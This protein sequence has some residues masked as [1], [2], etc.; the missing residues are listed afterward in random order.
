MSSCSCGLHKI[1]RDVVSAPNSVRN[2]CRSESRRTGRRQSPPARSPSEDLF[3]LGGLPFGVDFANFGHSVQSAFDLSNPGIRPSPH[4]MLL[5]R[6]AAQQR[7]NSGQFGFRGCKLAFQNGLRQRHREDFRDRLR[8][9][10][11][12]EHSDGPTP[13]VQLHPGRSIGDRETKQAPGVVCRDF[14]EFGKLDPLDVGQ[15]PGGVDDVRRLVPLAAH[16]NGG[17][18]R[19]VRLHQQ[20]V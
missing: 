20:P 13:S 10:C 2:N 6:T 12:G 17:Q 18:V 5:V 14:G 15:A 7:F 8:G 11:Q 9:L 3:P 16:R 19:G 4:G 1:G